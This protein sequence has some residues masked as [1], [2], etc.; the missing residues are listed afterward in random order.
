MHVV[1]IFYFIDKLAITIM[2]LIYV[3]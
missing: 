2:I 1:F 3:H